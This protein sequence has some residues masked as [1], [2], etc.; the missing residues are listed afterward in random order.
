MKLGTRNQLSQF[1]VV[2][3]NV[4][5]RLERFGVDIH[6]Q[7]TPEQEAEL[8]AILRAM[9]DVAARAKHAYLTYPEEETP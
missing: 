1:Q 6:G 9:D 3:G 5:K 2:A 8:G 4:R 7:L